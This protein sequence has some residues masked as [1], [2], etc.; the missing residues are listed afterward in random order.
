MGTLV[1]RAHRELTEEDIK[2][3]SDTYHAWKGTAEDI[4]YEDQAGY[5]KGSN[6]EEIREHEYVLTPGRYVG[7]E[8]KEEDE[9]PFEDKMA[10][11]TDELAEQFAK[12]NKL[13]KE[14][15]DNLRVIGYEF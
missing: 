2:K 10:R 14:I 5:C 3:I 13:E 1:D 11:L 8:E 4:E 9:E 6:I 7:I 15:R 12:S